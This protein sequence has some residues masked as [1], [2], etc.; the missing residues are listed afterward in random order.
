MGAQGTAGEKSPAPRIIEVRGFEFEVDGEFSQSWEA[1]K[2]L[3]EFN[4][5][6]LDT[7]EKLDL[8][9]KLIEGSVGVDEEHLVEMA[10]GPKAP[11]VEVI[12]FAA[13]IIA[14]VNPKN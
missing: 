8:S 9:L 11:A 6:D 4:R 7:F 2:M 5:D 14:A 12:R 1:F 13:E 3:R 10:G